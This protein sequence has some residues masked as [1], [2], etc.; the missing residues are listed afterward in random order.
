MSQLSRRTILKTIGGGSLLLAGG[1]NV[2][3]A[4][5]GDQ[6][7]TAL[8]RVGH[9]SP[10][11]PVVN[12]LIDDEPF[13]ELQGVPYG[14]LS[15]YFV[16]PADTYNVKVVLAGEMI[17]G[18][19]PTDN[20]TS[21]DTGTTA[22]ETETMGNESETGTT[23]TTTEVDE[24]LVAIDEDLTLD[25]GSAYTIVAA[26][27]LDNISAVVLEDD[28][29]PASD[30]QAKVRFGHFS[31]DAPAV[32]ITRANG[33]DL[34]SNLEFGEVSSYEVLDAGVY[35]IDIDDAQTQEVV[36]GLSDVELE[37]DQVY[38]VFVIGYVAPQGPELPGLSVLN[39]N[40][41]LAQRMA[42]E[43]TTTETPSGNETT[44]T[45]G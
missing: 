10:D 8:F 9:F 27:E 42:R 11:T 41:T 12:V 35:S 17:E 5:M 1:V 37:G 44:T 32:D 31:S 3:G 21:T 36:A 43:E 22:T 20:E 34:V 15:Q 45:A 6:E 33:D 26:D 23:E 30:S 2:A 13:P 4:Q 19:T 16:V 29:E 25:A 40:D 7:E 39:S 18:E 24:D 28:E 14:A 38:S